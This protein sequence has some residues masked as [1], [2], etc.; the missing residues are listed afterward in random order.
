MELWN[1]SWYGIDKVKSELDDRKQ[2]VLT[3]ARIKDA[4]VPVVR[5]INE[6]N[7]SSVTRDA[8]TT[9]DDKNRAAS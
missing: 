5:S 8:N 4:G 9:R 3:Q 6:N 7:V 2:R 1:T